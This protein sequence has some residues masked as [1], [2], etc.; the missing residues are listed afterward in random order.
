MYDSTAYIL[1]EAAGESKSGCKLDQGQ[2][3]ALEAGSDCPHAGWL[4]LQISHVAQITDII[5]TTKQQEC[6][7]Q[8]NKVTSLTAGLEIAVKTPRLDLNSIEFVCFANILFTINLKFIYTALL[9][10]LSFWH[11]LQLIPYH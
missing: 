10:S 3:Y 5:L 9:C 2:I 7:R 8:L 4:L 1:L 11:R 6:I